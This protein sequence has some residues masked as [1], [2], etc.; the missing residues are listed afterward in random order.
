MADNRHH[1]ILID[2]PVRHRDRLFGFAGVVALHQHDFLAVNAA[3]RVDILRCLRRAFPV[4]RAIGG[5]RAGER[6]GDADFLSA[7]ALSAA[8]IQP[9][10]T[11]FN[12]NLINF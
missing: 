5:V 12:D 8:P 6:P 9:A 10:I 4:L 2:Q 3:R 11:T 7:C 1:L